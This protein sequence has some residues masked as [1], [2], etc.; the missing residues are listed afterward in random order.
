[1]IK[2]VIFDLDGLLINSEPFWQMSMVEVFNKRGV[3]LSIDDCKTTTGMRVDEVVKYWALKYPE[4]KLN[5]A[6]TVADIMQ[7][8]QQLVKTKGEAMPGVDYIISF[9]EE[10]NIPMAIASASAHSLIDT[11]T[12]KFNIRNK[13]KVIQSAEYLKYGK[14]HPE[15]FINTATL[16]ETEPNECLVF[17][18][19]VYGILAAKSAMMKVVAVP[20]K[21]N[22]NKKEYCIAD[23]KIK[24]LNNFDIDVWND[25][26]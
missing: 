1:M 18:D 5:I 10:M 19:S 21:E 12:D 3:K 13:F 16:L 6:D 26:I 24:S 14:P 11:V 20:E 25:L 23:K 7:T 15:I 4:A 17:E 22:F 9:F 2:A 8:I